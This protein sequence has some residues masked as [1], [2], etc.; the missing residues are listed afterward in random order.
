[1][2]HCISLIILIAKLVDGRVA[3]GLSSEA[4]SGIISEPTATI[5]PWASFSASRSCRERKEVRVGFWRLSLVMVEVAPALFHDSICQM[6]RDLQSLLREK[7]HPFSDGMAPF[8]Y[9]GSHSAFQ[10]RCL[11]QSFGMFVSV[12]ARTSSSMS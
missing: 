2:S 8:G 6:V 12:L 11:I 9:A 1:M 10:M 3:D 4:A 5:A 7:S